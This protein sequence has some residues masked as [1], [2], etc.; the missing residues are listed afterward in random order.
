M[1]LTL[2]CISMTGVGLDFFRSCGLVWV[3]KVVNPLSS[4][5][6]VGGSRGFTS[7]YSIPILTE[8]G[9]FHATAVGTQLAT[10]DIS[11]KTLV[12]IFSRI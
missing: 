3:G 10:T 11:K 5:T 8:F 12:V 2:W 1:P 7:R 4:Q 6:G 9:N